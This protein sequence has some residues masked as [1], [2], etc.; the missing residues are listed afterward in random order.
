MHIKQHWVIMN[1]LQLLKV[2]AHTHVQINQSL[3]IPNLDTVKALFSFIYIKGKSTSVSI[4]HGYVYKG[5]KGLHIMVIGMS[6]SKI[7]NY[8]M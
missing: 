1:S 5:N 6:L 2:M 4:I 8:E 7:Y 3:Y